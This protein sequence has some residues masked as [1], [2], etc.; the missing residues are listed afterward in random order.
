MEDIW[1]RHVGNRLIAE[2][3][4]YIQEE[5]AQLAAINIPK[6]NEE[7]QQAFDTITAAVDGGQSGLYFLNGPAGTGKTFVYNTLCYHF[8]ASGKI[9]L[10]VASSG[11]ASLLLI[12]GR[13][14]HSTF[15]IPID[16]QPG[17]IC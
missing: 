2:Q 1:G 10:C 5:Q 9:V 12:G 3:Q 8:R 14:A 4:A 15:K 13:T 17:Q 7:Q 11:I 6:L 16:I